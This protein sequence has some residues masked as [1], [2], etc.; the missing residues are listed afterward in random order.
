VLYFFRFPL[1]LLVLATVPLVALGAFG[2]Q[3]LWDRTLRWSRPL[4]LRLVAGR[5]TAAREYRLS[6]KWAALGLVVLLMAHSVMDVYG[7]NQPVAF[8]LNQQRD[9]VPGTAIAWLKQYD[10]GL[11]YV[12]V[13]DWRVFWPW[14]AAAYEA[15]QPAVNFVYNRFLK[16]WPAQR[17]PGALVSASPKYQFIWT[18]DPAPQGGTLINN[19]GGVPLYAL[20]GALPFAFA[21]APERLATNIR[22]A[23]SEVQ[24]QEARWVNPNQL[25]VIANG[26][27]GAQ[28]VALV[29]TFP[30]WRATVDGR[31][32]PLVPL[33]DY[34]GAQMLDGTHTYEF[35]YE[36]PAFYAGL[37]V[38]AVSLAVVLWWLLAGPLRRAGAAT[39]RSQSRAAPPAPSA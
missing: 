13:G 1:R 31:P 37:G 4:E 5:G 25:E 27:A 7:V 23:P 15:E 18:G 21:V 20:P 29:S 38:S 14:T 36:P 8:T 32:I 6:L 22:L 19:L 30:G 39:R 34:L 35:V 24:A 12:S 2:L 33:S 26:T 11:Y 9:P 17:A 16:T 3:A 10:P 28:L